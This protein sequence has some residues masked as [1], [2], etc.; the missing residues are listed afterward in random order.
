M[1]V[2]FLGFSGRVARPCCTSIDFTQ[3]PLILFL[4]MQQVISRR[5]YSAADGASYRLID[6]LVVVAGLRDREPDANI[7]PEH[8][9]CTAFPARVDF[10][11]PSDE[12][13]LISI[14]KGILSTLD[15]RRTLALDV[16][17]LLRDVARGEDHLHSLSR[18]LRLSVRPAFRTGPIDA[19]AL[20]LPETKTSSPTSAELS[21]ADGQSPL[22]SSI[23]G[24]RSSRL[25]YTPSRSTSS[26]SSPNDITCRLAITGRHL[27]AC[28]PK[29]VSRR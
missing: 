27:T 24:N 23:D 21:T 3:F 25:P 4:P 7:T 11:V 8:Y 22:R 14:A 10:A 17:P 13:E 19:A 12:T 2:R 26:G 16:G 5:R 6:D 1:A 29:R 20:Q 18:L 9:V 28:L 15:P